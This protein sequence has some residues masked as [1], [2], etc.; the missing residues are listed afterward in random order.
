MTHTAAGASRYWDPAVPFQV[1]ARL[2]RRQ[3]HLWPLFV[4]Y[5]GLALVFQQ[6]LPSGQAAGNLLTGLGLAM[7][8]LLAPLEDAL[9]ALAFAFLAAACP[10]LRDPFLLWR[11]FFLGGGVIILTLRFF[12]RRRK[13][14]RSSLNRFDYLLAL[15]LV[16]AACS[17]AGSAS[18]ELSSLKLVALVAVLW[19]SAQG[20]AHLVETYGPAAP[21]RLACG[22]LAYTAGLLGWSI[23]SYVS[24]LGSNVRGPWFS[25]YVGHPNAWAV[26]VMTA[27]PWIGGP[28]LRHR[29]WTGKLLALAGGVLVLSY[30]LLIS[31]SRAGMLGAAF[32]VCIAGLVHG[33]RRVAAVI[34]LLSVAFTTRVLAQPDYFSQFARQYIWK[35]SR[36]SRDSTQRDRALE[37]REKP[38]KV[39]R[40]QF[41]QRPWFGQGFGVSTVAQANWSLA[42]ET[43]SAAV[44]TASSAWAALTQVGMVGS[45]GLFLAIL[46][47]LWQGLWFAWRVRDPWFTSVYISIAALTVNALFEGW[48]LAPGNYASVYFWIQCFLLNAV[49]CRYVPLR[50]QPVPLETAPSWAL[51]R[52]A[53]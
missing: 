18:M 47:L 25:G 48:L 21:R 26:L 24:P 19:V 15:F 46:G 41:E 13:G 53:S 52:R 43:G 20:G 3:S 17:V 7:A 33:S 28:L 32:A 1:G 14:R 5:A 51:A 10:G 2:T 29:N 50:S 22:L 16:V 12:I 31:G 39:M 40:Q 42:A 27:L 38:W 36:A 49:M 8:L 30:S 11:W 45:A 23:V 4:F 9:G 44:E 6:V 34:L 37:S 35:F